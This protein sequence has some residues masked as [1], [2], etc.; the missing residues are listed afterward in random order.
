ME[1]GVRKGETGTRISR[2]NNLYISTPSLNQM[3]TI[4]KPTG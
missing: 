2:N 1:A 4:R 3:E